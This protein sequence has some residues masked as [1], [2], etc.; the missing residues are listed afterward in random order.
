MKLDLE[1]TVEIEG[2]ASPGFAGSFHEPPSGPECEIEHVWMVEGEKKLDI[3]QYLSPADM[4]IVIE[5]FL[6]E[7]GDLE[8]EGP[9]DTVEERDM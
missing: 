4:E 1:I 6:D 9:Y 3:V 8:P 7:L 2:N 5:A